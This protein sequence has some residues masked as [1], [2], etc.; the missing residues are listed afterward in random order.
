MPLHISQ[1]CFCSLDPPDK[2]D[3]KMNNNNFFLLLNVNGIS[4]KVCKKLEGEIFFFL[5]NNVLD[6]TSI[7]IMLMCLFSRM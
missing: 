6:N 3:S 2:F 1:E 4:Y 7:T 5:F